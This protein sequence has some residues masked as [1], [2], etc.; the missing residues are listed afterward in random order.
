VRASVSEPSYFPRVRE[1]NTEKLLTRPNV[2][3]KTRDYWGGF[4]MQLVGQDIRRL[5]PSAYVYGSGCLAMDKQAESF[6]AAISLLSSNQVM[7]LSEYW[8]D[9]SFIPGKDLSDKMLRKIISAS[10]EFAAGVQR[11]E[12]CFAIERKFF[13]GDESMKKQLCRPA[14]IDKPGFLTAF[15]NAMNGTS[16][17]TE[18]L[19]RG[20]GFK[21]KLA[22]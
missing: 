6:L 20:R 13:D 3:V 1:T 17:P 21:T 4:S 5:L 9:I 12:E 18:A 8:S 15:P 19:S 11:A 16:A 22:P 10:E 7:R 2:S 14:Y